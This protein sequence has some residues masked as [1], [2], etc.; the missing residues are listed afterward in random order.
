MDSWYWIYLYQYVHVRVICTCKIVHVCSLLRDIIISMI[1]WIWWCAARRNSRTARLQ[2][3]TGSGLYLWIEGGEKEG[4]GEK[5]EGRKRRTGG[6][7]TCM[8]LFQALIFYCE[9]VQT[10]V[11][12]MSGPGSDVCVCPQWEVSK[13][14]Y[15]VHVLHVYMYTCIVHI[16]YMYMHTS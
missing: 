6:G 11:Y 14:K 13:R 16:Q 10:C 3:R 12:Y 2:W 7:D 4:T 15:N 8:Q 9:T 5:G 1:R